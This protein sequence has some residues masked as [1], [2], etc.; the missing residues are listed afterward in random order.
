VIRRAD[1]IAS[2]KQ[3]LLQKGDVANLA[4]LT[5]SWWSAGCQSTEDQAKH[6][7]SLCAGEVAGL[8]T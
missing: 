5:S 3:A 2:K 6:G 7:L 8:S 1:E 4:S